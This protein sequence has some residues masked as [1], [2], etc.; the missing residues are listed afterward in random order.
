[1]PPLG[2]EKNQVIIQYCFAG[3]EGRIQVLAKVC[4]G[5]KHPLEN[6]LNYLLS[7]IVDRCCISKFLLS[8]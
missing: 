3:G 7:K 1:M 8:Q 6:F 2:T 5:I 4:P